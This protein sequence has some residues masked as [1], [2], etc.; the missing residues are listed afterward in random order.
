MP[1]RSKRAK[2]IWQRDPAEFEPTADDLKRHAEMTLALHEILRTHQ[3]ITAPPMPDLPKKSRPNNP[4]SKEQK[5]EAKR[6]VEA[7]LLE[8]VMIDATDGTKVTPPWYK[9]VARFMLEQVELW[10]SGKAYWSRE[11]MWNVRM[12]HH[13]FFLALQRFRYE[14]DAAANPTD[15][16]PG[17]REED[18]RE[19][20]RRC[21]ER[22]WPAQAN[23][24]HGIG[25]F[26]NLAEFGPPDDE[27]YAM[28]EVTSGG[29]PRAAA[30]A[31]AAK[32]LGLESPQRVRDRLSGDWKLPTVSAASTED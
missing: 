28:F 8:H 22:V 32:C 24:P 18:R 12:T 11:R 27:I 29:G 5:Q 30:Y 17:E 21:R 4:A 1:T 16:I 6:L 13:L 15:E 9:P 23:T 3:I 10:A 7:S 20:A 31:Y 19:R 14:A 26:W 25:M 2:P